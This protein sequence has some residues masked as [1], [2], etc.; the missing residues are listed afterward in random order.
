MT[1]E[2]TE[3]S[4]GNPILNSSRSRSMARTTRSKVDAYIDRS[5]KWP[6]VM[7]RLRPILAGCGLTEEIKWG[8]PCFS[9]DGHNIVIFQEMKE[10]LALMF[11]K[12][13]L[14]SD[15]DGILEE[16]GPNSRSALRICF[17]SIDD[18]NRLAD[19]VKAYVEEAIDVEEAGLQVAP[20]PVLPPPEELQNRLETDPAFKAAFEA[21]TP[22]RQREYNLYFS[23]AKQSKTRTARVDKYAPKILAGKG[24]RD[25]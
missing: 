14:L 8:K 13:A 25:R 10:F 12:G 4:L 18:A 1:D 21:L 6:E 20:A 2:P 16:Q 9:Q 11:F 3:A 24:F 17:R 22:G 15:P 19:T 5:T 7:T 23:D